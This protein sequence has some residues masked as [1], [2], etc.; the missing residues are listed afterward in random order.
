MTE[1]VDRPE[2]E[3]CDCRL[4]P[5]PSST[6]LGRAVWRSSSA[7]ASGGSCR[8][9]IG[10]RGDNRRRGDAGCHD[11]RADVGGDAVGGVGDR[12]TMAEADG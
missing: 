7:S 9:G 6:L 4:P 2:R 10:G 3:E 11:P 1:E 12:S 8:S 5:P